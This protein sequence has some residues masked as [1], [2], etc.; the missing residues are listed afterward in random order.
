MVLLTSALVMLEVAQFNFWHCHM[1]FNK[2][3]VMMEAFPTFASVMSPMA[4]ASSD[5]VMRGDLGE[6]VRG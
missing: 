6:E 1:R 3:W 5:Q 4:V 2:K